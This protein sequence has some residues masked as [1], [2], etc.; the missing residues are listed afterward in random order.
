MFFKNKTVVITGGN[1]GIG[2]AIAER[3]NKDEA[4]I[5]IMGRDHKSLEKTQQSL[6]HAI[7]IA[8]NV[9]ILAD[10]DKLYDATQK[11]FGKMDVL[12]ANAGIASERSIDTV[13]EAYFDEMVDI[14]FKGLYFTVQRALPYLNRGASIILIS[15]IASRGGNPSLSVYSATKAAVSSLARSFSADL[16]SRQIRVNAISPGFTET[17]MFD[18][19]AIDHFTSFIPAGR[20]AKADEIAHVAYSLCLPESAY[21]MGADIVIDGGLS[22]ICAA[23]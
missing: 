12:I 5:V 21:I 15:S 2:K 3:F 10:L 22:S 6:H 13:D 1:H 14:N 4:N 9:E 19:A 18:Q 11:Q 16:L 20:F 7:A 17:E 23:K 8:G